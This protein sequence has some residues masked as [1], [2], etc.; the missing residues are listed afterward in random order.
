MS[1]RDLLNRRKILCQ[2]LFLID[3]RK[4]EFIKKL[5][6]R[7][8]LSERVDEFLDELNLINGELEKLDKK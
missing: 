4:E 6:G 1:K 2:Q 8:A 7:R 5:G 3:M